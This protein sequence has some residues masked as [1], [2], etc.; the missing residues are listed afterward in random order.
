MS[1]KF[2]F[3]KIPTPHPIADG[4][5]VSGVQPSPAAWIRIFNSS[6]ADLAGRLTST[7]RLKL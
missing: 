5:Y 4:E 1:Y 2:G 6:V 3:K 7:P